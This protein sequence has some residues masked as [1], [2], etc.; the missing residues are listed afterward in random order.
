MKKFEGLEIK[1]N[2]AVGRHDEQI[3]YRQ[4]DPKTRS[5][6]NRW[7]QYTQRKIFN[8]VNK[9]KLD[10]WL[11]RGYGADLVRFLKRKA[12]KRTSRR[13]KINNFIRRWQ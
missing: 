6:W 11:Y 1:Y 12:K 7:R 13:S 2:Y 4:Y 8:N 5:L 3:R 10:T 9:D